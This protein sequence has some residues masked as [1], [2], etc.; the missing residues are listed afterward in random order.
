MFI[1]IITP[2]SRPTNLHLI[3]KSINIPRE[4]YRWIVVCDS[5]SLPDK[6][7]IPNNCEIY[8]HK[9]TQSISGNSQRNFALDMVRE[10]YVYFND[11]DTLIHQELWENVKDLNNDFIT[12]QQITKHGYL[13][14]IGE[15]KYQ[16]IDSH[17]FLLSYNVVGKTR[18]VLNKYEADGLFAIEC[19][20]KSKNP[21][22]INKPL[23]VY[24]QL[25]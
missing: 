9:N 18:W 17:N 22:V 19:Y 12:F 10:G 15:V 2:C 23:S 4:N 3:S 14:L 24:N 1:N 7:L 11:D 25:R 6:E 13:R 20:K 8:T 5:E 21:L 16:R